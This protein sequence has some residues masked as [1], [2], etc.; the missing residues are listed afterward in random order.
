MN[1]SDLGYEAFCSGGHCTGDSK[2]D[3]PARVVGVHTDSCLIH[4]GSRRIRAELTGKM[5]FAAASPLDL[6]AVGDWVLARILD[7]GGFAVV[8]RLLP[9]KSMLTRKSA[10]KQV[11]H[12]VIAANIDTA[13]IMQSVG[14]DFNLRRLERCLVMINQGN[15]RPVLLLSKSDLASPEEVES[16]LESARKIQPGLQ[17]LGF[18]NLQPGSLQRVL[19]LMERGRTYCLLGSS[20][21]GKTTLLN[22]LLG[23]GGLSTREVRQKDGKGRHTTTRRELIILDNGA[24]IID[25]PGMRELGSMESEQGLAET[26]EDIDH[27]AS[28]CRFN[29]CSHTTEKG[30]AVLAA[31]QT[32]EIDEKRYENYMRIRREIAHNRMTLAEKRRKEKKFSKM[33]KNIMENKKRDI[34]G[35]Y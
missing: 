29:D 19:D 33:C 5:M 25:N 12:Q 6:P 2:D 31:L 22:N 8:D 1:L 7:E 28:D 24:M 26:F 17:A 10:G 20:G 34:I 15:I 3:A 16:S 14:R 32:G 18:S 21:V 35:R 23:D 30:C 9:R 11:E 4:D 13:F 27:F